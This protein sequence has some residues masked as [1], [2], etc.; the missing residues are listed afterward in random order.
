M[1]D[2]EVGA[3]IITGGAN[4]VPGL[5]EGMTRRRGPHRSLT[6]ANAKK[7][8]PGRVGGPSIRVRVHGRAE[9]SY[10]DTQRRAP[11]WDGASR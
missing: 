6:A 7:R 2:V 1:R 4:S 10:Y 5:E 11:L 3:S 9:R 8:R